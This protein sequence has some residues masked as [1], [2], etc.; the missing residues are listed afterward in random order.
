MFID[1]NNL[2]SEYNNSNIKDEVKDA[3]NFFLEIFKYNKIFNI[4]LKNK[5]D[6]IDIQISLND[7]RWYDIFGH[8]TTHPFSLLV[9]VNS[10]TFYFRINHVFFN[11]GSSDLAIIKSKTKK[12][13]GESFLR[14]Y[15]IEDTIKMIDFVFNQK[16]GLKTPLNVQSNRIETKGLKIK[17]M[18]FNKVTL[19][20]IKTAVKEFNEK[21][22]PEGFST[23]KYYDI[24]IEGVLYPPK[25]IMA[26][27]NYYATGKE[28][29][30]YFPGGINTPCFKAYERLGI[31][32]VT[33][34]NKMDSLNIFQII[35][36]KGH[37]DKAGNYLIAK[38]Q[39]IENGYLLLKG[40]YIFKEPKPSF[41][42]HSYFK[43]ISSFLND[44]Y[45]NDTSFGEF[46]VLK[47]D[48]LFNSPSAAAS[49][50]LN[51]AA[52]GP[53]EWKTIGGVTLR[54]CEKKFNFSEIV[55]KF[56]KQAKTT[57]LK[58][59]SYPKIYSEFKVK[60]SFGAGNQAKIP[61]IALLKEPNEVTEGIYPVYLYFK[62][63]EKLILAYGL[64]ETT[65][66]VAQWNIDNP[67]TITNFFYKNNL[68][69]P[70]RYGSSFIYKVYDVNNLPDE[71]ILN[72]ELDMLLDFYKNQETPII[73]TE[74][75]NLIEQEDFQL[76]KFIEDTKASGLLFTD[77]L[78]TRFVS[79]LITKPFVLLSG[80]SGSGKTK[81]AQTFAKWVCETD[82]QYCV[83]P[84]GAD[85]TNREP[86]LG[87]ENALN[88]EEYI[89]PENGALQ[90]VI[91]ADQNLNKPH[92]LILD[93]MNLSHVE[94]YFA[95]FLSVME[96]K[97]KF[98]L[99]SDL[100]AVKSTVPS[101][102]SWPKNLFVIGTVNIDETT[103]M[104][105]PKVLDRANVIEFRVQEEEIATFLNAPNDINFTKLI[106]NGS[107]MAVDFIKMASN[108]TNDTISPE[109]NETLVKFFTQLKKTGAEFGYRTAMEIHRLFHQL[110]VVNSELTT[111]QKID[112][113]IMQKL[114]PKL[115]GS[116]RKLC[117]VLEN[118]GDLCVQEI[119]V[120]KEFFENNEE[121]NFEI[122]NIRYP[123]SL[124]KI[125]RM[126]KGAIDNG[127][128]SY[129]EA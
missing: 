18:L 4:E 32:I 106:G 85:W 42:I 107:T 59:K 21:G 100:G 81:L 120:K 82:K 1:P 73:D 91:N 5:G 122:D 125:T 24:K 25:P 13:G 17:N 44:K 7:E 10:M 129:A 123:L 104:F 47:K 16:M 117:P 93:E 63:I 110:E 51:R 30:N 49:M 88:N 58:T 96:S 35:V 8:R 121:L 98:K 68:G 3:A 92:F 128:A 37:S 57:N 94:R 77:T 78:L 67:V 61:W 79:S 71:M 127:F 56:L 29:E 115:H 6:K 109:L 54:E 114:L 108:G 60:V 118:L 23:S 103:Y 119:D 76:S 95:D 111:N 11:D 15:N 112:I 53:N 126:Y 48:I 101:E 62:S 113:A 50:V 39:I 80:L 116:R 102:L 38:M 22:T 64:S 65:N 74:I 90:L 87:Y 70:D 97:E 28:I 26:I 83:V 27:A 55:G 46:Y 31:E 45:V 105:S 19:E 69:K 2:Y 9:G 34:S 52:N 14:L 66:P 33:K 124:E 40:S 86:L 20:N 75:E 12:L 41:L 99:H 36:S 89:L 43:L 72:D 84:V